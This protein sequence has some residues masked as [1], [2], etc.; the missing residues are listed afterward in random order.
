MK[1]SLKVLFTIAV[2]LALIT[3]MPTLSNS[4]ENTLQPAQKISAFQV[5]E[6]QN[7]YVLFENNSVVKLSPMQ[8]LMVQSPLEN[9]FMLKKLGYGDK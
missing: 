8:R 7:L 9:Y 2:I 6:K 4:Q 5:D 3:I 1:N